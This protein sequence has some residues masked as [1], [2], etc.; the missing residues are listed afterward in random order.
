MPRRALAFLV[1]L[2]LAIF[3]SFAST[4]CTAI[5]FGVGALSDMS[6]GKGPPGRLVGV[7]SGTQVTVWLLDGRRLEGRYLGNHEPGTEAAALG[8]PAGAHSFA[9]PSP[10]VIL[11]ERRGEVQRVPVEDVRRVSVPFARGKKVGLL[12]GAGLDG[13]GVFL[14]YQAASSTLR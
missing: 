8:Q 6:N 7:R 4:G 11:L 3:A 1:L 9:T 10:A 13:I 5:G 12:V 2:P 14:F